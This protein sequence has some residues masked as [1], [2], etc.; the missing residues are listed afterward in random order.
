MKTLDIA[1]AGAGPAGLM[2]AICLARDGHAV[3]IFERF[4]TPRPI[5]AGLM[6]QPTGLACLGRVGLD[7][8]AIAA[9]VRIARIDGRTV[10]GGCIFDV[11]Y[12]DLHPALFGL[13]I[14]RG[15]LFQIL[16]NEV[17][18]L[19][20][21]IVGGLEIAGSRSI[22]GGRILLDRAGQEH[23]PFDLVV[24]ATGTRSPLRLAEGDVR[25]DRPYPYGALW[26][27]VAVPA[28][29][30]HATDLAQ[31][32]AG[33]HTMVGVLPVGRQ[34]GD[35]RQLAAIF[36]SLRRTD[37]EAWRAAGLTAWKKKVLGVW[38]AIG[39]FLD[40]ILQ[41]EELT[42]ATYADMAM[43]RRY[44]ERLAF[45]GDAGRTTSPQLGQG[46]NLALIDATML[47]QAVR[48]HA[49]MADALDAFARSRRAHS[50]FYSTASRWLTPFFQS[51]SRAAGLLRD[52]TFPLMGHVPYL[53]REMVRTL[54]GMKT[55]LFSHLDPG[56]WHPPYRLR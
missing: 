54:A 19:A 43:R 9:G 11:S 32:Y 4:E 22:G 45:I 5:G 7:A 56:I 1:V 31:T 8:A 29:W 51:D 16:F 47:A 48:E 23:G 21:P 40:Q 38:P 35:D 3:R 15:A 6:L 17:R 39:P 27:I 13:G 20:V 52:T 46:C 34:P 28:D 55:G 30:P 26:A 14:H 49:V 2:A 18:R 53:K 36:W 44:C 12:G 25:V 33:A 41:P 37:L 24:D 42:F 10:G 50:T